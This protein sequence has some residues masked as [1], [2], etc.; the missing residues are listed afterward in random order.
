MKVPIQ[1]KTF[2]FLTRIYCEPEFFVYF[3]LNSMLISVGYLDRAH[4]KSVF[5]LNY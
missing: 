1:H 4:C 5:F 3:V 2:S